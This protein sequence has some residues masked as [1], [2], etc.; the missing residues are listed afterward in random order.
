[1]KAILILL[2]MM[3]VG[4]NSDLKVI[5]GNPFVMPYST[6]Y[7]NP[8]FEAYDL[9]SGYKRQG[10]SLTGEFGD[11]FLTDKYKGQQL[12]VVGRVD[13][14]LGFYSDFQDSYIAWAY[15]KMYG[16]D[17]KIS[18][19]GVD[20]HALLGLKK[21]E[22]IVVHGEYVLFECSSYEPGI[23]IKADKIQRVVYAE[24]N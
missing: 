5:D 1:M 15:I 6:G 24:S 3:F 17:T 13:D 7:D 21:N 23:N 19:Y 14:V 8:V 11:Q 2:C 10:F 16:Q 20:A 22:L 9:C 4:C 18:V 12:K